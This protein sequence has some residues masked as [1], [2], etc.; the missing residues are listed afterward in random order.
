MS[1]M[2][3]WPLSLKRNAA[4]IE[5]AQ[6][7]QHARADY[8]ELPHFDLADLPLRAKERYI[9]IAKSIIE[10]VQPAQAEPVAP[11]S[12]IADALF[13]MGVGMA[14]AQVEIVTG[15]RPSHGVVIGQFGPKGAA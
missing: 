6:A 5:L 15:L 1:D 12:G 8:F 11:P 10:A 3:N 4:V 14:R 2:D 9:F 13:Q 7:I